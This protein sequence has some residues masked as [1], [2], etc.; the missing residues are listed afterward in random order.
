MLGPP[1]GRCAAGRTTGVSDGFARAPPEHAPARPPA[2]PPPRRDRV[3]VRVLRRVLALA[4]AIWHDSPAIGHLVPDA[5]Q[6]G[7]SLCR[8]IGAVLAR[9]AACRPGSGGGQ[10]R[11]RIASCYR[12]LVYCKCSPGGMPDGKRTNDAAYRRPAVVGATGP[13]G[14]GRI[15]GGSVTGQTVTA[16][17]RVAGEARHEASVRSAAG[18][19]RPLIA[20]GALPATEDRPVRLSAAHRRP[21]MARSRA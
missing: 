2:C 3:W 12:Q 15:C 10:D 20:S 19:A 16:R 4:A 5:G 6:P 13:R 17:P 8:R 7:R 1:A 21:R 14:G 18:A 11:A 9:S